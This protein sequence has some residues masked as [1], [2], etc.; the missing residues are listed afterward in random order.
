MKPMQ[1]DVPVMHDPEAALEQAFIDGYLRAKGVESGQVHTLAQAEA[2]RLMTEASVYAA[3]K[4]A[5][6][7]ARAHYVHDV[8]GIR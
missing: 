7:E 1:P 3:A 2:T 8:H 6:V 4:L 5:E